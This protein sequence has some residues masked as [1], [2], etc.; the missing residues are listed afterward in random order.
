MLQTYACHLVRL[1]GLLID[2]PFSGGKGAT[3]GHYKG[4]L[5]PT[6]GKVDRKGGAVCDSGGTRLDTSICTGEP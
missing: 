2:N 1:A 6:Q 5:D 3:L 4:Q